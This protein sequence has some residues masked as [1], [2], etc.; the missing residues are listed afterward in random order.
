MGGR[1]WRCELGHGRQVEARAAGADIGRVEGDIGVL[2]QPLLELAHLLVGRFP[3]GALRQLHVDD[4]LGPVG[5]REELLLHQ[6]EGA[7]R[8]HESQRRDGDRGLAP[9]HAPHHQLAE[10]AIEPAVI[11]VGMVHLGLRQQVVAHPGRE[12]H[13]HE[14]RDDQREA[15]HPEDR[16]G[17]FAG[18]R[19]GETHRHETDR[20]DER[21][22]QHRE[23]GRGIGIGRGLEPAG[24]LFQ[25]HHHHLDGDDGIVDQQTE[26][27]DQ[28]AERDPLE[29]DA[30]QHHADEGDGQHQ[31]HRHRHD[32]AG[33]HAQADERHDQHDGE[34]LEQR[35]DELLE[36]LVDD[37]GLVG[38]A[39]HGDADGQGGLDFGHRPF[40]RLAQGLHVAARRHD[41]AQPDH[42]L[43]LEAHR[44]LLR[45][46]VAALDLGHVGQS[47]RAAVGAE[48]QRGQLLGGDR[49][50][51]DA[52]RDPLALGL[53]R[54]GRH[55]GVLPAHD[56]EDLVDRHAQH[57][58]P[59]MA[60]LDVDLLVLQA[61]QIGL[62]DVGHA[63][64]ALARGLDDV[65]DLGRLEAVGF[66]GP[67]QAVGVAV[68]VVEERAVD[69]RRQGALDVADLL[70]HL[71][72]QIGHLGGRG[73]VA[74]GDVDHRL[75]G[76]GVAGDVVEVGQLLQLG[77]DLLGD[78]LLHLAQWRPAVADTTIC[79]M[80]KGGS[81][82]RD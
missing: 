67:D 28:R 61:E 79:L 60:E 25:L 46:L 9:G 3:R 73:V 82:R 80:V 34:R 22:G 36:R 81:P 44:D 66:E 51:V 68:F 27:D 39:V 45:I 4:Q 62:G 13:G 42:R 76:L 72:P 6:G 8:R 50:A 10:E 33:A 48:G 17:V 70:A 1:N 78:P 59:R 24:A 21:A 43:A 53:D 55:D 64:Q 65:L 69:A 74:Q 15:D 54:A 30:E 35:G 26:R 38:D 18:A 29:V 19:A 40:E 7:H 12:Q 41:D 57:G 5:G 2:A 11:G 14:P 63:Q 32:D 49:C 31:R 75:A 23:S 47:E 20:G 16:V 58:Q 37:L 52:D 71:V 56:L 77:L